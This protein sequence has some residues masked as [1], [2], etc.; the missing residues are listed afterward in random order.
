MKIHKIE[1]NFTQV[2]NVVLADAR[3]S[4]KAKGLY[5]WLYSKPDGWDFS[6]TRAA[7]ETRDGRDSTQAAARE[8]EGTGYLVR[9]KQKDGRM[10]Y[11]VGIKPMTENPVLEQKPEPDF[12]TE[13]KS[14]GGKTRSISNTERLSNTEV[15]KESDSGE[16]REIGEVIKAFES[17]NHQAPAWYRRPPQRKA[18]AELIRRLG[19]EQ[20]IGLIAAIPKL[21]AIPFC[22][23]GITSPFELSKNLT[24]L[25]AFT[26][27]QKSKSAKYVIS[28]V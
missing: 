12:P 19:F 25:A 1:S 27:Q 16:S 6:M 24:K 5:C 10:R 2:S 15:K 11:V 9:Q 21:M 22:P 7:R 28:S 20:T 4:W 26:Q 17:F 13:G 23:Q 8:L 14:V 18:A 3:L